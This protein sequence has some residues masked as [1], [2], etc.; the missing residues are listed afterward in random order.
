MSNLDEKKKRC[1]V[2]SPIGDDNSEI[3]EKA[4]TVLDYI[5]RPAFNAE[6]YE[7]V[8]ADREYGH[9]FI[10]PKIV[11]LIRDCDVAVAD[12]SGGNANV[13]YELSIWH[14][15]DK[16][17]VHI[18]DIDTKLYFHV[19][20]SEVVRYGLDVKS[21]DQ[22]VKEIR[23]HIKSFGT[24]SSEPNPL[25]QAFSL[26]SMASSE[27][28]LKVAISQILDVVQR[29]ESRTAGIGDI[30][31]EWEHKRRISEMASALV[32]ITSGRDID[33]YGGLLR[34]IMPRA[35]G[36]SDSNDDISPIKLD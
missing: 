27:D 13:F 23:K 22:A 7:P 25:K 26:E 16:P 9:R 30:F 3:R 6:G 32:N 28:D 5:I 15:T 24:G 14:I 18:M 2:M 21:A 11:G 34:I 12:L 4:D 33:H 20:D 35:A 31:E 8:R 10:T 29:I 17:I 19:K 36:L 1:F